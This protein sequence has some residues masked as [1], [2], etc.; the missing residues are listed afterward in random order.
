MEAQGIEPWSESAS[1]TAST[2][3]GSASRLAS[4]RHGA[5]LPDVDLLKSRARC[6]RTTACQ[7]GLSTRSRRPG[8]APSSGVRQ[9]SVSS[10]YAASASSELAGKS[11]PKGLSRTP[12]LGTRRC[13]LP[14]RRSQSPPCP[15]YTPKEGPVPVRR[16]ER[17]RTEDGG[18]RTED[19]GSPFSLRPLSSVLCPP[20]TSTPSA[21]TRRRSPSPAGT[22][23]RGQVDTP[24]VN[25]VPA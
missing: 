5:V 17:R 13:L 14:T 3:V 25:R 12:D 16:T 23:R 24:T 21:G 22:S 15:K 4:G 10:A 6:R 20:A 19:G 1:G 8:R 11:V 18:R 2:C 7:S 9:A